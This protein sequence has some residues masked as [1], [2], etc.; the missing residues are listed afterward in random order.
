MMRGFGL[1]GADFRELE[2]AAE[3]RPCATAI[4][5]GLYPELRV[6]IFLRGQTDRG[7]GLRVQILR[8]DLCEQRRGCQI[9]HEAATVRSLRTRHVFL[10]N[11][12]CIKF[13]L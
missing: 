11:S 6:D 7:G 9:F 5:D 12:R 8:G 1:R 2:R 13:T 3:V 4:D 10:R